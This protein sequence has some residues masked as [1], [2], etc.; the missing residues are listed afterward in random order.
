MEFDIQGFH[1]VNFG[2]GS[3]LS[4]KIKRVTRFKSVVTPARKEVC[5]APEVAG[6]LIRGG[7][8]SS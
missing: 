5:L 3:Q 1:R 8:L 4:F 7:L 6:E 2:V